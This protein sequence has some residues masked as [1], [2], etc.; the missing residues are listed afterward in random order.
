LFPGARWFTKAWPPETYR[1]LGGRLVAEAGARVIVFL[2]PGD[3][4]LTGVFGDVRGDAPPGPGM[5]VYRFDVR[6]VAGILQRARVAVANDSAMMHLA[7]AC[8]VPVVALFGPTVTGFGFRP[9]G[10]GSVVVERDLDCRPCSLHGGRLCPLGH[11]ECLRGIS[12]EEV[13]AEVLNRWRRYQPRVPQGGS[14]F[15]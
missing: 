14:G 3:E 6:A 15:R 5:G 8:G 12:V 7:V 1:A 10:A 13:A 4:A 11:H 2:G 9:L